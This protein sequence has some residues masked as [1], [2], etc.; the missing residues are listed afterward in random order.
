MW[1]AKLAVGTAPWVALADFI[2]VGVAVR[3]GVSFAGGIAWVLGTGSV[4]YVA[5]SLVSLYLFCRATTKSL[6]IRVKLRDRPPGDPVGYENW[7]A[8]NG[9]PLPPTD[10]RER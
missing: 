9:L 8:S 3:S 6:G 4:A 10:E 5:S 1:R 2:I 7:C